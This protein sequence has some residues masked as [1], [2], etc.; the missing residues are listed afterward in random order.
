MMKIV[1]SLF[2]LLFM[3]FLSTP[4]LVAMVERECDTSIFYTMTEEEENHKD[5]KLLFLHSPIFVDEAL[6]SSAS[7]KILYENC[8][9]HDNVAAAIF[10]PP[11]EV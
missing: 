4:T 7:S 9:K 2:L 10:S 1:A 11:P 5:F 6:T 8:S 3:T